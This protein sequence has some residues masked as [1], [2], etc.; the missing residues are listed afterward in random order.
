[1]LEGPFLAHDGSTSPSLITP[2]C[3]MYFSFG[4]LSKGHHCFRREDLF[5]SLP[6]RLFPSVSFPAPQPANHSSEEPFGHSEEESALSAAERETSA[7]AADDGGAPSP[8]EPPPSPP[9]AKDTNQ[10]AKLF[11]PSKLN[12]SV[13]AFHSSWPSFQMFE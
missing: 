5:R 7:E 8:A 13:R 1:M 9:R 4:T 10:T 6:L 12:F 3:E 11:T 2:C